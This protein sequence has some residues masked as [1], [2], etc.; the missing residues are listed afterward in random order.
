M[1]A[2]SF[3]K[4]SLV[5]LL[6]TQSTTTTADS[7]RRDNPQRLD[8]FLSLPHRGIKVLKKRFCR[9]PVGHRTI[10]I[11]CSVQNIR[12]LK[13]SSFNNVHKWRILCMEHQLIPSTLRIMLSRHFISVFHPC[14]V[15]N[16]LTVLITL[17]LVL[18]EYQLPFKLYVPN[19][20]MEIQSKLVGTINFLHINFHINISVF[21]A[22]LK[23]LL[24]HVEFSAPLG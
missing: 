22:P 17:N 3:S 5:N 11:F 2:S 13:N 9:A 16:S 19:S 8:Q 23:P 10:L 6:K 12:S 7:L 15:R 18:R 24:Q 14:N 21:E 4:P 20:K 1:I